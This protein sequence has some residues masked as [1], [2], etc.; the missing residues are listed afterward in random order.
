MDGTSHETISVYD[1]LSREAYVLC[2]TRKD[3]RP[4]VDSACT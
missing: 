4:N 2:M 3:A 1:R